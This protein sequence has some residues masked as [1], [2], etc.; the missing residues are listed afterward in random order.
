MKTFKTAP[1]NLDFFNTH[2]AAYNTY[3]LIGW[4]GQFL[5]FVSLAY[6][7][8][9]MLK[10]AVAGGNIFLATG[11]IIIIGIGTA[12]IIEFANRSLGRPAIRP[13]VKKNDFSGDEAKHDKVLNNSYLFGLAIIGIISYLLSGIGSV[14]YGDDTG[15]KPEL[16]NIDSINQVYAKQVARIDS[17][18]IADNYTYIQ[19]F[20]V[21]IKQAEAVFRK[22]SIA[23]TNKAAKYNKCANK[24]GRDQ[25]YCQK[26]QRQFLNKIDEYRAAKA[27]SI[28]GIELEKAQVIAFLRTNQQS[29]VDNIDKKKQE[30]I[31]QAKTENGGRISE[32]ESKSSFRGIIFLILTAIGQS[33][34][35][36]TTFLCLRIEAG[37]GIEEEIKPDEFFLAPSAIQEWAAT[38][39]W[40]W[41]KRARNIVQWAFE[42]EVSEPKIPYTEMDYS[43]TAEDRGTYVERPDW[44]P[45]WIDIGKIV[46]D[47]K[48][49]LLITQLQLRGDDNVRILAM[50]DGV[51][52]DTSYHR[53]HP[54]EC[55]LTPEP[56]DNTYEGWFHHNGLRAGKAQPL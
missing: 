4:M 33:L 25:A 40:K 14:S 22:D 27:D 39:K 17:N 24:A 34:F 7:I 56:V 48:E 43:Q 46:Y 20:E 32:S 30:A 6:G 49:A 26:K 50:K 10:D 47:K 42:S 35:Y 37:S 18:L 55:P 52:T 9:S 3:G 16:I 31:A 13:F 12:F 8:Y 44:L 19:P 5:S 51:E 1:T 54:Y 29:K 21:R 23:A 2:A 45:E 15:P 28:N 53:D 41:G 36:Y 11:L 38:L